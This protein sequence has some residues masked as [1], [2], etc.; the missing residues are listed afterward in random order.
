MENNVSCFRFAPSPSGRMHFGNIY[1]A[2]LCWLYARKEDSKFIIRME[3]IDTRC[4]NKNFQFEILNDLSW[5]GLDWDEDPII[6]SQHFKYYKEI[7]ETIKQ[8]A[9]VY[10]CFC[11]R[12]DLHAASAPHTSDGTPIYS[13]K[14]K[15]LSVEE[16]YNELKH[17]NPAYR[18]EVPNITISFKDKI[19]GIYSQNLQDECG[20]FILQRSDKI[21][22]Y[23]LCVVADDIYQGVSDVVRGADLLSSTPRQIY[24]YE[25]L[26]KNYP[27]YYHHPVL[28]SSDGKRLSKRDKSCD[29][30][31]LRK[32]FSPEDILGWVA[33]YSGQ[34]AK[35][36]PLTLSELLDL[37]QMD[38]VFAK[39]AIIADA[40][41]DALYMGV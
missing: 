11:K 14:C 2:V 31:Y 5:L 24:L 36:Q 4:K 34:L 29:M 26:N 22:A 7:F 25:L 6:Q 40:F 21:F 23:Q 9:N 15:H 39:S 37:F 17:K 10:P 19:Q 35:P 20:D 33:F 28:L 12:A 32:L 1:S 8:N 27:N 18:I 30:G 3:D 41:L 16:I 13:G 38:K